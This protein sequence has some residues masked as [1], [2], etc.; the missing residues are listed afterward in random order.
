VTTK[1]AAFDTAR[2]TYHDVDST[3]NHLA[4]EETKEDSVDAVKEPLRRSVPPFKVNVAPF[5]MKS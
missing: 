5:K 2:Q 3:E 4:K 1:I